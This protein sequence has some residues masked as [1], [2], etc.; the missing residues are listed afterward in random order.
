M[1]SPRYDWWPNAVRMVRNYPARKAGHEAALEQSIAADISGMPK[2][3]GGISR[4]VESIA[5]RPIPPAIQQEYEAVT[6]AVEITKLMPYG[7]KRMELIELIY[8]KGK[9]LKI[10]DAIDKIGIAEAT[11]KRWHGD[12]IRLVGNCFGYLV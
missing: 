4:P 9:K 3:G 12:F 11:G 2:G 6:R 8:W 7:D 10:C 5:L 1:S